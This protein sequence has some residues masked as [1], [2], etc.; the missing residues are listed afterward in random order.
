M[1]HLFCLLDPFFKYY[2]IYLY[3]YSLPPMCLTCHCCI[4][5]LYIYVLY[6]LNGYLGARQL[7]PKAELPANSS[8]PGY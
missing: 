8:G 7:M 1:S 2:K 6:V 4:Y 5:G 3:L